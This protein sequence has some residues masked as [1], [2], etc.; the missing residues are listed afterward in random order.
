MKKLITIMLLFLLVIGW[1]KTSKAQSGVSCDSA[2]IIYATKGYSEPDSL[3]TSE[4]WYT[5]AADDTTFDITLFAFLQSSGNRIL[6]MELFSGVCD[7]LHLRDSIYTT[8][9]TDSI[10]TLG[11][12]GLTIGHIYRLKITKTTTL[13]C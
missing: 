4:Q 3:Q 13:I 1:S 2:K 8:A 11:A 6:K 7:T 5:F 9:Y 10:I 12:T